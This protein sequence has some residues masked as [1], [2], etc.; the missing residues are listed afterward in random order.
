[1]VKIVCVCMCVCRNTLVIHIRAPY[2]KQ[3]E[4]EEEVE[5]LC[6]CICN[7]ESHL[8]E[9]FL[10][11]KRTK[12]ESIVEQLTNVCVFH[13]IYACVC[14]SDKV[15]SRAGADFIRLCSAIQSQS[16]SISFQHDVRLW[17]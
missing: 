6:I 9:H 5:V 3:K 13:R 14:M 16:V 4:E 12:S 17:L 2:N 10:V 1:M 15:Y 11:V 7:C 8:C